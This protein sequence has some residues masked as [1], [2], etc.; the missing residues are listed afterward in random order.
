MYYV[1]K[2]EAIYKTRSIYQDKVGWKCDE[3][4]ETGA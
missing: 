2:Q 3:V 1:R 4:G